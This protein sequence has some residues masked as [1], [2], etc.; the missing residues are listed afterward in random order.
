MLILLPTCCEGLSWGVWIGGFLAGCVGGVRSEVICTP[1]P[2]LLP[3][4]LVAGQ[5]AIWDPQTVSLYIGTHL[6]PLFLILPWG[7]GG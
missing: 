2:G 5:K 3:S 4:Q 1:D 6:V 7:V